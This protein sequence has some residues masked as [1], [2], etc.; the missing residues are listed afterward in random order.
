LICT[1]AFHY[2]SRRVLSFRMTYLVCLLGYSTH[3]LLD[4]CT[5]YGTQLL[6]PLTNTRFAWNNI[7]VV[8]PVATLPLLSLVI[9]SAIRANPLFAR[10]GLVWFLAYLSV[11]FIQRDRANS[12]AEALAASRG[13]T[14][15][16]VSAK[17]GFANLILWKSVYE[18]EDRYYVDGIRIGA[19]VKIYP[20]QSIAKLDITR[21]LP[22]LNSDTQQA[23]DIERFRWFSMGYLAL[24]PNQPGFIIDVRYSMLPNEINPLWGIALSP[25]ALPDDHVKF[26]SDRDASP[27][28]L[29]NF[30]AMLRGET[31]IPHQGERH[32]NSPSDQSNGC[33]AD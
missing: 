8:D 10:L 19:S 11:G 20:G 33:A 4:A 29:A 13:H 5:T 14:P 2:W 28:R 7:A 15:T 9:T 21:D 23:R 17:P 27:Q 24:D 1:L 30:S 31:C 6:W 18:F 32:S 12:A 22:W 16:A 3:A 25:N 26:V